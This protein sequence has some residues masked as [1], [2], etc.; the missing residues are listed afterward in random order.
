MLPC[1]VKRQKGKGLLFLEPS[2]S[3]SHREGLPNMMY[4]LWWRNTVTVDNKAWQGRKREKPSLSPP[5]HTPTALGFGQTHPEVREQRQ[6]GR[7]MA[8]SE[9]AGYCMSGTVRNNQHNGA[10]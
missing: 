8:R 10:M 4:A 6:L 5:L 7:N 9:W 1:G 2:E 3:C